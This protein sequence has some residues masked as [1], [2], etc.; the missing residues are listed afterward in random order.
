V[1]S[2]IATGLAGCDGYRVYGDGNVR[3]SV[4]EIWVGTWDEPTAVVV[5]L[6]DGRRGLLLASDIAGVWPSSRFLTIAETG[7][8]L[9]LEPPHLEP[10]EDGTENFAASWRTSGDVLELAGP[11]HFDRLM[12]D[13]LRS[14]R[15]ATAQE[16]ERPL[17]KSLAGLY[18]GVAAIIMVLIALDILFS[19]FVTGSPP[20]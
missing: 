9:Q 13:A 15:G 4:E 7:R 8:L 17:W 20:Y 6:L 2:Q 10:D 18:L 12:P 1:I 16:D 14:S 19:Y 5:R 3:G 11:G